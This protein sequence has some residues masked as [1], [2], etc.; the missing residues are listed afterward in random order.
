MGVEPERLDEAGAAPGGV[1]GL[2]WIGGL[3][4]DGRRLP[5]APLAGVHLMDGWWV[6]VDEPGPDAVEAED[7]D[8]IRLAGQVDAALRCRRHGPVG[9][10]EP[11]QAPQTS[12][13]VATGLAGFK[14]EVGTEVSQTAQ[15]GVAVGGQA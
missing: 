11:S 2:G 7:E 5:R 8:A 1:L 4:E 6:H 13:G 15:V 9:S 3:G 14:A 10:D 12:V